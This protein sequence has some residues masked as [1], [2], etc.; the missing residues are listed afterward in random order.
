MPPRSGGYSAFSTLTPLSKPP[1]PPDH[2]ASYLPFMELNL[3]INGEPVRVEV[4]AGALRTLRQEINRIEVRHTQ[5]GQLAFEPGL[6]RRRFSVR[7]NGPQAE[8]VHPVEPP[9]P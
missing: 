3:K 1:R 5:L 9:A 6:L 4:D 7:L 2:A 8:P